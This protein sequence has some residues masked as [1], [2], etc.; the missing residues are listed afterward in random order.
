MSKEYEQSFIR[1]PALTN[2]SKSGAT[3]LV[4]LAISL[5]SAYGEETASSTDGAQSGSLSSQSV[6]SSSDE[7]EPL[8]E[9]AITK[10]QDPAV[11]EKSANIVKKIQVFGI[12]VY[13]LD[14]VSD[15]DLKLVANVLAQWLDNDQDGKPDNVEVLREIHVA[16]GFMVLGVSI[17]AVGKWHGD[18]Q[19]KL[20]K[21]GKG[22]GLDVTTINHN[23][24]DLEP[25]K[26]SQN[27]YLTDGLNPP[28]AATEETFH[29]ISDLGYGGAYPAVF[30]RGGRNGGGAKTELTKAMDLARGGHFPREKPFYPAGAWF[31]RTD[32]CS[33]G[34]FVGE[35]IHWGI[36]THL[37]LNK[38]R[39]ENIM[40]QWALSTAA[41]LKA[42][43]PV[44]YTLLTD[45]RYKFPVTA[46]D[47]TYGD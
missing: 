43:D 31:T 24:Y 33:Y 37:G 25:S 19:D 22:Y 3:T 40:D 44:L 12:N 7:A 35:Y 46:P 1:R 32:G 6:A 36:I 15:R 5:L 34:C 2:I 23:W 29:L 21:R 30:G 42:R 18:S 8:Y 41:A 14:G 13:A 28:D 11:D 38:Q 47:S 17:R 26:Y 4:V 10:I 16:E 27:H 39:A 9:A 45:P 20:S